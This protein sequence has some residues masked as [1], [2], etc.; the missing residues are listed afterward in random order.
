MLRDRRVLLEQELTFAK[1]YAARY[2]LMI[3]TTGD[4]SL[5]EQ[6]QTL[7]TRVEQLQFDL[8]MLNQLI[9]EG[10]N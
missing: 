4:E 2:Y 6:Y 9:S 10:H 7:R 1:E 8:D 5:S 3:V